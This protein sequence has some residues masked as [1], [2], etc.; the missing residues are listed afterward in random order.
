MSFA[1][2]ASTASDQRHGFENRLPRISGR[3]HPRIK[4]RGDE[5]DFAGLKLAH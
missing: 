2:S 1:A 3:T 5:R 4:E